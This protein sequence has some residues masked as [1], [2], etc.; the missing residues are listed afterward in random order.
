MLYP[1]D[2]LVKS[3]SLTDVQVNQYMCAQRV[4]QNNM[5]FLVVFFPVL[6]IAGLY[7]PQHTAIAGA[8]VWLGRLVTAIG[9]WSSAEKRVYGG[10]FHIPEFYIIYLAV[11]FGIQLIQS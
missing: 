4:H 10:W 1:T 7:N 2:A 11:R 8:I 9:Y 5:E 3:L 6:L